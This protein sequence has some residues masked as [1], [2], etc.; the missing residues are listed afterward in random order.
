MFGLAGARGI[1]CRHV[2]PLPGSPGCVTI[3]FKVIRELR[4]VDECREIE[5]LTSVDRE[6]TLASSV[7]R[8]PVV[9]TRLA[10]TTG[11]PVGRLDDRSWRSARAVKSATSSVSIGPG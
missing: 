8:L 5:C 1:G 7:M 2:R 10:G 4:P 11:L 6:I 3:S 9:E